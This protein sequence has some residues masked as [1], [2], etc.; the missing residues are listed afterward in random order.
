MH[1][2]AAFL[3]AKEIGKVSDEAADV[4]GVVCVNM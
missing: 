1:L 2:Q 4:V 3:F